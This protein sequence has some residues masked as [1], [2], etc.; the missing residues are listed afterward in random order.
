MA[1]TDDALNEPQRRHVRESLAQLERQLG[2]I[3]AIL[4]HA[5]APGLFPR[6]ADDL[7]AAERRALAARLAQVR[8]ALA[9]AVGECGLR[10]EAALGARQAIAAQWSVADMGLDDLLPAAMRAYGP[11]APEAAGR[12]EQVAARLRAA[13]APVADA[14]P[15]VAAGLEAALAAA[16]PEAMAAMAAALAEAALARVG[17]D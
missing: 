1:W 17:N 12:L 14:P 2:A 16:L 9:A 8:A 3:E 4:A 11:L 15:A 5:R 13:L 6:Y 7:S 10:P